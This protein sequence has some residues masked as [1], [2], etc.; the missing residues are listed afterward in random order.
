MGQINELIITVNCIVS[1][2]TYLA[3]I[4]YRG[5]IVYCPKCKSKDVKK[6]YFPTPVSFKGKGWTR[7]GVTDSNDS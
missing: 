4:S 1:P 7:S 3:E 5:K 2:L 6:I